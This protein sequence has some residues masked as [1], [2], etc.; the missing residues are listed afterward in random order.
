[1]TEEEGEEARFVDNQNGTVTDN[2]TTLIWTREDTWQRDNQWVTWD[3]AKDYSIKL[4]QMQFAGYNDWRL[5]TLEETLSL[6]TDE[7]LNRDKYDKPI[8][9]DPVFP[10]GCLAIFWTA[11]GVGQDGYRVNFNTGEKALL[12]KSKSGRMTTRGVRGTPVGLDTE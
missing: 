8:F 4:G 11:D 9:L 2:E 10:P 6:L 3:E 5:P 12:Y 7:A 1:M